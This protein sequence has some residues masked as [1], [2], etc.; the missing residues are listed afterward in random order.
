MAVMIVHAPWLEIKSLSRG[1]IEPV[2]GHFLKFNFRKTDS[3]QSIIVFMFHVF[4][5]TPHFALFLEVK[6]APGPF[7][8]VKSKP[9]PFFHHQQG[10]KTGFLL[11]IVK[12]YLKNMRSEN[13]NT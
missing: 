9:W 4:R 5:G 2:F 11:K 13:S 7:L 6:N 1:K 12:Y 10:E 8:E 3:S